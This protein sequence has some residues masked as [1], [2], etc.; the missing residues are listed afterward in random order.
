MIISYDLKD[1]LVT[2]WMMIDACFI[3]SILMS[4]LLSP[5]QPLSESEACSCEL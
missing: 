4:G 2:A 3:Q 5:N 1:Q